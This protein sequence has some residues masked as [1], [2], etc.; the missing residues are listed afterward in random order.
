MLPARGARAADLVDQRAQAQVVQ[1][2]LDLRVGQ[3]HHRI[4]AALLVAARRQRVERERIAV[5]HGARLLHQRGK[6]A[7]FF[8]RQRGDLGVECHGCALWFARFIN[9]DCPE[10]P[11]LRCD[12]RRP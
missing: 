6:H 10:V 11:W 4:A 2:L 9:P 1:R 8:G 3:L 7:G 12:N 5:G